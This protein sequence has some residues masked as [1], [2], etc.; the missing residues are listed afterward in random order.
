MKAFSFIPC[1]DLQNH[2]IEKDKLV[3][4]LSLLT[5]KLVLVVNSSCMLEVLGLNEVPL[6]NYF[7]LMQE[8]SSARF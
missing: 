6:L 3:S 7:L 4:I 5:A 8:I 2:F 1:N